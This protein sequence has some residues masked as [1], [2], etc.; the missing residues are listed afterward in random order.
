M[1]LCGNDQFSDLAVL[2]ADPA[3][4]PAAASLGNSDQLK[5]GETVI[6]IGF[7]LGHFKNTVTTGVGSATGRTLDTGNGYLMEGLI[8]TDAA[9]NRGNSS[10]PL[11]NLAAR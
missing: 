9:I 7:P 11:V 3:R 6:A 10:G 5:P 2:K 1:D 4:L 8:Q